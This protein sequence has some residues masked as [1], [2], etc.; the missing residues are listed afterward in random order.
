MVEG[1]AVTGGRS[2]DAAAGAAN[3]EEA[4]RSVAAG[5]ACAALAFLAFWLYVTRWMPRLEVRLFSLCVFVA[6]RS[7]CLAPQ[8]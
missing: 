7:R 1:A 6:A 2:D 5:L 3:W 8:A 4:K